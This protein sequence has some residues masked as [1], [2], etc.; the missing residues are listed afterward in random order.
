M[1]SAKQRALPVSLLLPAFLLVIG[2][3]LYPLF[4]AFQLSFLDVKLYDMANRTWIGLRNYVEVLTDPL[5]IKVMQNS[6]IFVGL[7][8]LGQ[9][10]FG[11]ALASVLNRPGMRGRRVF[12]AIYILPWVASPLVMSYAWRF[13]YNPRIGLLN[14][15]LGLVGISAP[16][17]LGDL[18]V[19]M[20]SM[21]IAN[22]WRGTPFSFVLQT[23]GIQS[24]PY[25]VYDA[26]KVDGA[27]GPQTLV[28]ITL[29]LMKYFIIMN[30]IMVTMYTFNSFEA[31]MIMTGGGPLY[32][33]EVLSLHMYHTAFDYGL[34]GQGS[35]LAVILFLVNLAF[36]VFYVR[37]FR[38]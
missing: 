19:V 29:P 20:I 8:I 26:A 30:L 11:F 13:F 31:I 10:G 17:W 3:M 27:S 35:A 15:V 23:A 33:T 7:S 12:R 28:Y 5:F 21:V 37:K 36:T 2:I 6:A 34:L 9:V 24:I 4:Y 25:E 18:G 16:D 32:A 1:N 38:I 22:I 14:Y